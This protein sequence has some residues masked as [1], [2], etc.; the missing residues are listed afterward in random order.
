VRLKGKGFPKYKK[1]DQY[2]DLYVTFRVR[3]PE[4]LS[5]EEKELFEKLEKI[6]K[7]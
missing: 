1:K 6:R 5:E 3:L 4:T 2:G 7:A